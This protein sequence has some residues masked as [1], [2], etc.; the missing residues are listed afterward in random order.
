MKGFVFFVV[1][2]TVLPTCGPREDGRHGVGTL[3]EAA[4]A[5]PTCQADDADA[6]ACAG[7]LQCVTLL[8]ETGAE[9]RC[10]PPPICSA[11]DC[12][13]GFECVA[14]WSLPPKLTCMQVIAP[15]NGEP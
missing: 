1:A 9:I 12:P 10:V 6:P 15:H 3:A 2:A 8:V 7:D 4:Q 11:L 13:A 14:M 5:A